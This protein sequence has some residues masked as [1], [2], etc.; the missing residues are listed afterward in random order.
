MSRLSSG[1]LVIAVCLGAAAMLASSREPVSESG[2][3]DVHQ[4][5]EGAFRDGLYLG[6][7]AA[8]RGQPSHVCRGRWSREKDRAL[9]AEG[10]QQGYSA[11]LPAVKR[12]PGPAPRKPNPVVRAQSGNN[13][14]TNTVGNE[15]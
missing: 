6:K 11:S 3:T 5:T 12:K 1:A 15:V 14:L 7:L 10:Y 13:S 8:E 4:A 2:A 9:F